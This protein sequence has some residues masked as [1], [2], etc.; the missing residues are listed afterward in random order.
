[1]KQFRSLFASPRAS[2][3][4]PSDSKSKSK[5]GIFKKR[6]EQRSTLETTRIDVEDSR[7]ELQRNSNATVYSED[8]QSCR[9]T[10]CDPTD[11][12]KRVQTA[13]HHDS[14]RTLSGGAVPINPI[15]DED[16]THHFLS[17]TTLD[18]NVE[19]KNNS[20]FDETVCNSPI[21]SVVVN[22]TN[23]QGKD[24]NDH[25]LPEPTVNEP[26]EMNEEEE[27]D[28]SGK[29]SKVLDC[30]GNIGALNERTQEESK[31]ETITS[32]LPTV[33]GTLGHLVLLEDD[34]TLERLKDLE[35]VIMNHAKK[36]NEVISK[37][38]ANWLASITTIVRRPLRHLTKITNNPGIQDG[39]N[40]LKT[41]AQPFLKSNEAYNQ[42]EELFQKA[43]Q[44]LADLFTQTAEELTAVQPTLNLLMRF[45]DD[46]K[47]SSEILA[48]AVLGSFDAALAYATLYMD[49]LDCVKAAEFYGQF[50]S[51]IH[52]NSLNLLKEF[53][54]QR[55]E[56]TRTWL[57][58]PIIKWAETKNQSIYWL[59]GVPGSGKS[60]IAGS[61]SFMLNDKNIPTVGFPCKYMD[62]GRDEIS[63]LIYTIAYQLAKLYPSTFGEALLESV[64]Q[65][66]L[67][68]DPNEQFQTL[69]ATPASAFEPL[70]AI[71]VAIVDGFDELTE[72]SQDSFMKI[73]QKW[74]QLPIKLLVTSR[75]NIRISDPSLT[76]VRHVDIPVDDESNLTDIQLFAEFQLNKLNKTFTSRKLN[77]ERIRKISQSLTQSSQGLFV[78]IFLAIHNLFKQHNIVQNVTTAATLEIELNKMLQLNLYEMYCH[79]LQN[80]CHSHTSQETFDRDFK[81]V[82]GTI[83]ALKESA[84]PSCLQSLLGLE[85]TDIDTF[86]AKFQTLLPIKTN[87]DALNFIHKTVRDYL[88]SPTCHGSC[89]KDDKKNRECQQKTNCCHKVSNQKFKID[90]KER[91]AKL[92]QKCL[93]IL[94]N[95]ETAAESNEFDEF[96]TRLTS[97]TV[98]VLSENMC[99]LSNSSEQYCYASETVKISEE[100]QYA[101]KYCLRHL[102]DALAREPEQATFLLSDLREFCE[103]K[104]L[105]WMEAMLLMNR[106]ND[107]ITSSAALLEQLKQESIASNKNAQFIS[108]ILFDVKF[109]AINFRQ[110]LLLHP[111]HLYKSMLVWLPTE[112][113]FYK[114]Y[115]NLGN[116]LQLS[117]GRDHKWGPLTLLGHTHHVRAVAL[118][119]DNKTL[120]S[121]S[122]D[123][124][125]K[126]WS[127]ET[128]ECIKT[129]NVENS[130]VVAIAVSTCG[131]YIFSGSDDG[132]IRRW[133]LKTHT[134]I[135]KYIG[136]TKG[137]NC[138]AITSDGKQLV[139]GSDDCTVR[140]WQTD[141]LKGKLLLKHSMKVT[142]VEISKNNQLIASGSNDGCVVVSKFDTGEAVKSFVHGQ[143]PNMVNSIKFIDSDKKVISGSH[144][145]TLKIWSLEF[146]QVVELDNAQGSV[147]A[148]AKSVD[149]SR[150]VSGHSHQ[151]DV[152]SLDKYNVVESLDGH[153]NSV[154]TVAISSDNSYIV[155][156]STDNTIK[157]WQLGQSKSRV[158]HHK[159]RIIFVKYSHHLTVTGSFD[160]TAKIWCN[161]TGECIKTL[162]MESFCVE[163]EWGKAEQYAYLVA[164]SEDE[165]KVLTGSSDSNNH[166]LAVWDIDKVDPEIILDASALVSI[167]V[168]GQEKRMSV[169][170]ILKLNEIN[171]LIKFW[172]PSDIVTIVVDSASFVISNGEVNSCLSLSE[173]KSW[174]CKDGEKLCWI[175]DYAKP[176][177]CGENEDRFV[178]YDAVGSSIA[179]GN[180]RVFVITETV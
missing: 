109:I 22:V 133:S 42:L 41:I 162:S 116:E 70:E 49:Y 34:G 72:L 39:V 93:K 170:E 103:A 163:E 148:T 173:C 175:P 89:D 164:I 115:S 142:A 119:P 53:G 73:L 46:A 82:F 171:E 16:G 14:E 113:Q 64:A 23:D 62:N 66:K 98:T 123:K 28:E 111:L 13:A 68:A 96:A 127:V 153:S 169:G 57:I 9:S 31:F 24:N 45:P 87:H 83:L 145:S 12:R 106:L 91:S 10:V 159:D 102:T 138:V 174:I 100:L 30:V 43:P 151:V 140:V 168:N 44:D 178:V 126:I 15:H 130:P 154:F 71:T 69:I 158:E 51:S 179:I 108:K 74:Q 85:E 36:E 144:D 131:Q 139:S 38:V 120:I 129:L 160:G 19:A 65:S 18:L 6:N 114:T 26:S 63:T 104:L 141:K 35:K 112:T 90:P 2:E 79:T 132:I 143:N 27:S 134:C 176:E 48:K 29:G 56:N 146:D 77:S 4:R 167:F 54:V 78:W 33:E 52:L 95:D 121:G 135:N 99:N 122:K 97:D 165:L 3:T 61:I 55:H 21:A 166:F 92:A 59:S 180:N 172:I 58:D 94:L 25:I 128:G 50:S 118:T 86:L 60:V 177:E 75:P 32:K 152:W 11:D 137:V 101:C 136:H 161:E 107:M 157:I 156:G 17:V 20:S 7:S 110:P 124:T 150:L 1:M 84:T 149:D 147:F 125:I 117:V 37:E 5:F 81:A 105:F 76:N 8:D 88:E 40:H 47:E 67:N 80:V 155:S